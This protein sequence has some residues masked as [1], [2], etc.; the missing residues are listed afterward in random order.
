M[1]KSG[2]REKIIEDA[3]GEK[4]LQLYGLEISVIGGKSVYLPLSSILIP[5]AIDTYCVERVYINAEQDVYVIIRINGR[6]LR[7]LYNTAIFEESYSII[8][9]LW[10]SHGEIEVGTSF[11]SK[12]KNEIVPIII[13]IH[14]LHSREMARAQSFLV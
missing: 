1:K 4:A 5:N 11:N 14:T 13:D 7:F 10:Y 6:I 9:D 3:I 2:R 8:N 12:C